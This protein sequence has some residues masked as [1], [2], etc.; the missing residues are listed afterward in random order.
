VSL[1]REPLLERAQ[2]VGPP[3]EI[4]DERGGGLGAGCQLYFFPE[5]DTYMF[6]AINLGTVT[7]SPL[8]KQT[9]AAL[10][11]LYKLILD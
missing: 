7:E 4:A 8:H 5:K 10:E 3:E 9:A 11:K 6:V 2:I 1:S